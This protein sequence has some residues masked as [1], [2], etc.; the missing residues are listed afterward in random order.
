MSVEDIHVIHDH[1]HAVMHGEAVEDRLVLIAGSNAFDEQE[2]LR[3]SYFLKAFCLYAALDGLAEDEREINL[4]D[5]YSFRLGRP[6]KSIQHDGELPGARVDGDG[7]LVIEGQFRKDGR[8]GAR[9]DE[10]G[11][12]LWPFMIRNPPVRGCG[13]WENFREQACAI[14][15][16][17]A[18]FWR[19]GD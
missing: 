14:L 7:W 9:F 11:Y 6:R 5:G 15:R 19:Y 18:E 17:G 4:G 12:P 8:I 10:R 1:I 13:P 2:K 16:Q 3:W